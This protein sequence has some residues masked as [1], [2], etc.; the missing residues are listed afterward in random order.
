[1]RQAELRAR[2][3]VEFKVQRR[4]FLNTM[5][6][7]H[8]NQETEESTHWWDGV[9]QRR[10]FGSGRV[11][12]SGMFLGPGSGE[13]ALGN[14]QANYSPRRGSGLCG[15]N[16]S[17]EDNEVKDEEDMPLVSQA[18]LGGVGT[19][20]ALM[21]ISDKGYAKT[22]RARVGR[23]QQGSVDP[24]GPAMV[25]GALTTFCFCCS[26]TLSTGG[27]VSTAPAPGR[28]PRL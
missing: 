9:S 21:E 13:A 11:G 3:N 14:R 6:L 26:S 12:V 28:H 19:T 16:P 7:R 22:G 8:R 15:D 23:P 24:C 17:G 5:I 27:L 25:P 1:M 2:Y 20:Q 10:E 18:D 4:E